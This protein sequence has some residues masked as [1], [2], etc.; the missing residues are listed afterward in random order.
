MIREKYAVCIVGFGGMGHW[1]YEYL[2]RG[3]GRLQLYSIYDI[4]PMRIREA[5]KKGYKTYASFEEML[6][7]GA[8]DV[9]LIATPNEWHKPYAVRALQ[10]GKH[11]ISEKPV[12]LSSE[13]LKEM[14][15]ASEQAGRLFTVH[16][17]RRWDEDFLT[18]KE[19][20]DKGILGE[21]FS[22]ESRVHGSRG[23]P[24]DWRGKKENGGGMMLDWGVHILDQML[25]LFPGQISS[26]YAKMHHI[27]NQEV[28]DGFRLVL[29][30]TDGKTA[31][32]EV[33]TSNFINLPRWYMQGVNGTAMMQDF[34]SDAE[35]VMVENWEDKDALPVKTA[36]GLTKTMA[37]RTEETIKRSVKSRVPADVQDF[38]RNVSA[39]LDGKEEPLIRHDQL[40]R[41]MKLMETA[42]RS[43]ALGQVVPFEQ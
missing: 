10:A 19:I 5:E 15:D 12:A 22:V 17:N 6:A 4:D 23:I 13:E 43:D 40:M 42:F 1:H 21:V 14:I 24:G 38:Y 16:Q 36:A 39:V 2:S 41:V 9:V 31:L 3:I 25:L 20:Y 29:H 28:D 35:I 11:V 8:V 37:P 27:T 34:V 30:Y 26:V 33:G 7:D 18:M 32:L